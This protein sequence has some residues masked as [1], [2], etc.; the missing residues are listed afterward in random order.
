MNEQVLQFFFGGHQ[1]AGGLAGDDNIRPGFDQFVDIPAAKPVAASSPP[2]ILYVADRIDDQVGRI[3]FT[4][5][6]NASES[7]IIDVSSVTI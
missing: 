1:A 5:N 2:V 6:D 3:R 7:T 4:V